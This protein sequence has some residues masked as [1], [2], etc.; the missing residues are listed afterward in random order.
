M[1]I[2]SRENEIEIAAIGALY[3]G[4]RIGRLCGPPRQL[5]TIAS[6]WLDAHLD[7]LCGSDP[8]L[9]GGARKS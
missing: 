6:G 9:G 3:E 8:E 1:P 2:L 7:H 5:E 4:H